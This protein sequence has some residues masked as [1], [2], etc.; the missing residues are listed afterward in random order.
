MDD[1][2][3]LKLYAK[4]R[5]M[6]EAVKLGT[7]SN[8]W[9]TYAKNFAESLPTTSD[10]ALNQRVTMNVK[11]TEV[12]A[13]DSLTGF[14]NQKYFDQ[15]DLPEIFSQLEG[16]HHLRFGVLQSSATIPFHLD[17]PY[18][19]RFI[20]MISGSHKYH[21]ETGSSYVM[22]QGD[23]WFINGSYKHSVENNLQYDRIALL[24]KFAN[25]E[26]NIRL[27]NELL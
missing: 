24:G 13:Y 3:I 9:L 5:R 21:V 14:Y 27:I 25:S 26:K 6:P 7:V 16:V 19:L 15:I 4:N 11:G 23:L 17:E 22:E 2:K 8:N 12:E 10:V 20:C 1:I 18:N